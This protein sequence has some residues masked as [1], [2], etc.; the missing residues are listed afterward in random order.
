MSTKVAFSKEK[1]W[2]YC[3]HC[4]KRLP[5]RHSLH[6]IKLQLFLIPHLTAMS[7]QTNSLFSCAKDQWE[8]SSLV[9]PWAGGLHWFIHGNFNL[10]KTAMLRS[11]PY[12]QLQTWHMHFFPIITLPCCMFI[13][14]SS[15]DEMLLELFYHQWLPSV[16]N[17]V[18]NGHLATRGFLQPSNFALERESDKRRFKIAILCPFW[19][20]FIL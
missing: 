1:C 9:S 7:L 16:S 11:D 14:R 3:T 8:I 2:L 19:I 20:K 18:T 12:P 6:W 15:R 5:Q 4:L 17:A 13:I 10:L